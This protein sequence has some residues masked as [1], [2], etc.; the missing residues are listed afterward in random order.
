[1]VV[2]SGQLEGKD[3]GRLIRSALEELCSEARTGRI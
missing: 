1:M 3:F 2:N